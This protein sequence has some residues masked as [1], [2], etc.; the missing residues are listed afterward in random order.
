M[1]ERKTLVLPVSKAVIQQLNSYFLQAAMQK[2][3]MNSSL[4]CV[5]F[6]MVISFNQPQLS[7]LLKACYS[8]LHTLNIETIL[9]PFSGSG[10]QRTKPLNIPIRKVP[11]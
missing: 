5:T 3:H 7:H 1:H 4:K 6:R 8:S 2:V 10:E 9:F 11:E